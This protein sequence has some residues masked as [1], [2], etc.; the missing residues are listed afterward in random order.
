MLRWLQNNTQLVV[1][2]FFLT[3]GFFNWLVRT[4]A[5]QAMEKKA[6]DA[7]QQAEIEALRTGR[8]ASNQGEMTPELSAARRLEELAERR[9]QQLEDL[10]RRAA[11]KMAT[12]GMA[13]QSAPGAVRTPRPPA[14]RP[15]APERFRAAQAPRPAPAAQ[16]AAP[17]NPQEATSRAAARLASDVEARRVQDAVS[18]RDEERRH[19]AA[20]QRVAGAAHKEAQQRASRAA[21][22]DRL[23][24]DEEE[25]RQSYDHE[26][27]AATSGSV[28]L[29]GVS[30]WRRAMVLR[31]VLGP[32]ISMRGEA[33]QNEG[34]A[35]GELA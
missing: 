13:S 34:G 25:R 7:R 29:S 31:E 15:A 6:R 19:L 27:M 35:L 12:G 30:E 21:A 2:F 9:R 10:R 16:R 4:L 18:R 1:V 17:I 8:P 20:E 26:P 22:A 24:A 28:R 33:G 14:A 32:P 3:A 11:A 5:K 23:E